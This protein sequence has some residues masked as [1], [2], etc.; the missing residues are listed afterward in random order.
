MKKTISD[1]HIPRIFAHTN[2][3]SLQE[4]NRKYHFNHLPC[5]SMLTEHFLIRLHTIYT[6]YLFQDYVG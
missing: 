2:V 4:S 1:V 3:H 6:Q 5:V